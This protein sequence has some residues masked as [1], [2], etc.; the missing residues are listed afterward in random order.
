MCA[1]AAAL[2]AD[3]RAVCACGLWCVHARALA[4]ASI[5]G[6]GRQA[7]G[8]DQPAPTHTRPPQPAPPHTC[9]PPPAPSRQPARAHNGGTGRQGRAERSDERPAGLSRGGRRARDCGS[10][11]WRVGYEALT[12]RGR[13]TYARLMANGRLP[14]PPLRIRGRGNLRPLVRST[15]SPGP[16]T[17]PPHNPPA[18]TTPLGVRRPARLD[19]SSGGERVEV[20]R[21]PES[22]ARGCDP[23]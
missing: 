14:P 19:S 7:A 2:G 9:P 21:A 16:P 1:A 10:T 3:G 13:G 8:R 20:E 22:Q 5:C 4:H 15:P 18:R 17:H 23:W 11:C 12:A 6:E